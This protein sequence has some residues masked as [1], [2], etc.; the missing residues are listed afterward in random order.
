MPPHLPIGSML[1]EVC[2]ATMVPISLIAVGAWCNHKGIITEECSVC[3]S[4]LGLSILIPAAIFTSVVAAIR[5]P[6]DVLEMLNPIIFAAVVMVLGALL[7][8]ILDPFL[9]YILHFPKLV[10]R[11]FFWSCVLNNALSVPYVMLPVILPRLPQFQG[12]DLEE[13]TAL[14]LGQTCFYFLVTIPIVMVVCPAHLRAALTGLTALV[15]RKDN[16]R[17]ATAA[18]EEDQDEESACGNQHVIPSE[19]RVDD[20]QP[21]ECIDEGFPGESDA[22]LQEDVRSRRALPSS[23]VPGFVNQ[24]PMRMLRQ[25]LSDPPLQSALLALLVTLVPS[26]REFLWTTESPMSIVQNFMR[27]L[28]SCVFPLQLLVVGFRLYFSFTSSSSKRQGSVLLFVL[29]RALLFSGSTFLALQL[30]NF[31]S[32][33]LKLAMLLQCGMPSAIILMAYSETLGVAQ[34]E[35]SLAIFY[36]HL[37]IIVVL[38]ILFL[39]DVWF[40]GG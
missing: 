33:S 14:G 34:Q 20:L 40:A 36:G 21:E 29:L 37:L 12:R 28:T 35:V 17:A 31:P 15:E 30:W 6:K 19:S 22:S 11:F 9:K 13:E 5:S 2:A 23:C 18:E 38:P 32:P 3:L 25:L 39:A 27:L 10:R 1:L 26:L 24:R 16:M 7:G 4:R 8:L